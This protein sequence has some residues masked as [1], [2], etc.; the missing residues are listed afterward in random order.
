MLEKLEKLENEKGEISMCQAIREI[1][2]DSRRAGM[3]DGMQQGIRI[4]ILGN[5]EEQIPKARIVM[6]LQ[7][8]FELSEEEANHYYEQYAK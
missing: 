3:Q 8:R 6:K 2:E 7:W 1:A 5:Q 4:F